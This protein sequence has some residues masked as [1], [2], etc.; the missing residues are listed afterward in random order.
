M[1]VIIH[2]NSDYGAKL[3]IK[4]EDV[5]LTPG[6][7]RGVSDIVGDLDS[8]VSK[9]FFELVDAEFDNTEVD[10]TMFNNQNELFN[11]TIRLEE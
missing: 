3:N 4:G 10:I 5:I 6:G 1:S 8:E 11:G 2:N 7:K 9:D